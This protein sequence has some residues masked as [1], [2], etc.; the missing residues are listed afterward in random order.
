MRT[1]PALSAVLTTTLA[2]VL[3]L[4]ACSAW[5][6]EIQLAG[7]RL[8][9]HSLKVLQAYG[10]PNCIITGVNGP[11]TISNG[12]SLGAGGQVATQRDFPD[13]ASPL[14]IPMTTKENMWC[15]QR[16]GVVLG[17]VLDR[18]G[19]VVGLAVGGEKCDWARTAMGEPL[20]TVK[21]GDSLQRV[22]DRYGYPQTTSVEPGSGFSRDIT[23]H[24]GYG[25]NVDF[26]CRNMKVNRIYIWEAQLRGTGP[27][28][29]PSR[30]ENK[31]ES[32]PSPLAEPAN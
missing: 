24:Y 14:T 13:W 22:I 26:T 11:G 10:Q 1:R 18:D 5:C 30:I 3:V 19:Y 21:L 16:G 7:I 6:E 20:R 12:A 29:L 2:A 15:Y 25:Q 31:T 23:L 4:A 17:V 28:R 27:V 9:Q 32:F 8:G